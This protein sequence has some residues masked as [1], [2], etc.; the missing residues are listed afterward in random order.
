MQRVEAS[1]PGNRHGAI[2]LWGTIG[3]GI[4]PDRSARWRRMRRWTAGILLF[5]PA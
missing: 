4:D 5:D 3:L 2:Y 1:D